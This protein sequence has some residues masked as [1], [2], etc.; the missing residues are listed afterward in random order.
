MMTLFYRHRPHLNL[1]P[2]G[3]HSAT[4]RVRHR[5]LF[6]ETR[7][8]LDEAVRTSSYTQPFLDPACAVISFRIVT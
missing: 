4:I 8:D 3:V 7:R 5:G 6:H 2:L 1:F